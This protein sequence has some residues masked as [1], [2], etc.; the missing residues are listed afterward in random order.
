MSSP[1]LGSQF[2]FNEIPNLAAVDPSDPSN[3]LNSGGIPSA[4]PSFTTPVSNNSSPTVW[5][6][7]PPAPGYPGGYPVPGTPQPSWRS[8]AGSL[9]E[10]GGV[11]DNARSSS[12]SF[13]SRILPG[14][15][16]LLGRLAGQGQLPA[17]QS[18]S[19]SDPDYN[20]PNYIGRGTPT[21]PP[22]DPLAALLSYTQ[23]T[24]NGL[25]GGSPLQAAQAFRNSNIALPASR[26]YS[27]PQ[28]NDPNYFQ[29]NFSGFITPSA[30]I[31]G[32]RGGGGAGGPGRS[33]G[34]LVN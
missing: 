11:P 19:R 28:A 7:G 2:R 8:N 13:F 5:T 26:N 1:N 10:F 25:G 33:S 34:F 4:F 21:P 32:S 14:I 24:A 6:G 9:P 18:L 3:P 31:S 15:G 30:V 27:N 23:G 12:P 20:N 16:M 29:N 17:N 22:V